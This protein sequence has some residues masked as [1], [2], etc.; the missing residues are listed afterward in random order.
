[1]TASIVEYSRS[2]GLN[3]AF[4]TKIAKDALRIGT[5]VFESDFRR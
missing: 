1:M 3:A 4:R 2:E 5:E